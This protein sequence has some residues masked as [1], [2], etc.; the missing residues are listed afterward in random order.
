MPILSEF[1]LAFM[2]RN[3]P[4]FAFS[5]AGHLNISLSF[6]FL[7]YETEKIRRSRGGSEEIRDK[8]INYCLLTSHPDPNSNYDYVFYDHEAFCAGILKS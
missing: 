7:Q 8:T 4:K 1:F 3:L 6:E 5:S 2:G